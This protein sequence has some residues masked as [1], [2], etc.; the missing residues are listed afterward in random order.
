MSVYLRREFSNIAQNS[1][2]I[3][4]SIPNGPFK[5]YEVSYSAGSTQ[6]W[7]YLPDVGTIS[8]SLGL[9]SGAGVCTIETTDSPPD[10][11]E[12]GTALAISSTLGSLSADTTFNLTGFSAFRINRSSGTIKLSVRC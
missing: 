8:V 5:Y 10:I 11:I 12:A 6:D 3:S 4:G 2:T 9:T 7:I 1:N